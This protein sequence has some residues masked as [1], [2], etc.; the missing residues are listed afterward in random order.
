MDPYP[1]QPV[2]LNGIAGFFIAITTLLIPFAVLVDEHRTPDVRT[3][4]ASGVVEA[5]AQGPFTRRAP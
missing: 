4:V 1:P 3:V 5:P 2:I